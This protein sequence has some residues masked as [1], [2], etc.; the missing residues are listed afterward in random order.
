MISNVSQNMYSTLHPARFCR[1]LHVKNR[2]IILV[3]RIVIGLLKKKKKPLSLFTK[4]CQYRRN[5][6]RVR[7]KWRLFFFFR[8]RIDVGRHA[9]R[10]I[11]ILHNITIII[12]IIYRH[13]FDAKQYLNQTLHFITL[14][15][16]YKILYDRY[17][18]TCHIRWLG[19][20]DFW[21]STSRIIYDIVMK[22]VFGNLPR[23]LDC[24]Q[25]ASYINDTIVLAI[26]LTIFG[27]LNG[28]VLQYP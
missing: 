23:E 7:G 3:Y 18:I 11:I 26:E 2:D 4:N 15:N 19:T 22:W 27:N 24:G 28:P 21:T 13:C 12:N 17:R 1:A 25:V 8:V 9:A 10:L 5:K 20:Y 6:P 14:S 16:T